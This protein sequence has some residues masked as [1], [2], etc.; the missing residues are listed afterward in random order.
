MVVPLSMVNDVR[1][2]QSTLAVIDVD[3]DNVIPTASLIVND[4]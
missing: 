2:V 3:E 1:F 4:P